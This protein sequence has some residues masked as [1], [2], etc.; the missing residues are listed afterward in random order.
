MALD[1]GHLFFLVDIYQDG[2]WPNPSTICR[3][4]STSDTLLPVFTAA[5]PTQGAQAPSG[6]QN[7]LS[8]PSVGNRV[9]GYLFPDKPYEPPHSV[10]VEI[11]VGYSGILASLSP[12]LC[13][14]RC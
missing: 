7:L 10:Y 14:T 2:L 12:E 1:L 4:L 5:V 8:A 9:L 6:S 13:G 11:L 3:F